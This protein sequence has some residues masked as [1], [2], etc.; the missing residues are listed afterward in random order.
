MTLASP[1]AARRCLVLGSSG[2]IGSHLVASA[3]LLRREL[4]AH[5]VEGPPDLDIRDLGAVRAIVDR[6]HPDFVVHL[7]AITFVP[8]SV[9]DPGKAFEVNFNGTLNV[10]TALADAKF[11]GRMLFVSSAEVYGAVDAAALPVRETHP[12]APRTPY[13]VS[14]AAGELLCIQHALTRGID[15][16]IVRPFNIIGPGQSSKFAVS[17]FAQQ[18]AHLEQAGGGTLA[19]GNLDVTRDFI[20]VNDAVA[21]MVAILRGGHRAD[22]YNL[23]SG[24][25]TRL[26]DLLAELLSLASVPID[27]RADPSRARPAEQ[28]RVCGDH[29]KLTSHTEWQPAVPLAQTL[30]AILSDWRRRAMENGP[31]PTV[32]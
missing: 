29:S 19:V 11:A 4:G 2:F 21:A 8:D 10:L 31:S 17:S 20:D 7:A 5:V 28:R 6:S 23:C 22:P 27:V 14:K 13:A 9:A 18:V 30:D 32:R 12:Y 26:D 3:D 24:R 25:E 15:A 1:A 16:C